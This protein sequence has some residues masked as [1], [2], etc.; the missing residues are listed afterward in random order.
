MPF[1]SASCR[2]ASRCATIESFG[3]LFPPDLAVSESELADD[4]VPRNSHSRLLGFDAFGPAFVVRFMSSGSAAE[5]QACI[6]IS[7]ESK[8]IRSLPFGEQ[9]I[10]DGVF[11][12]FI[13][14]IK[15]LDDIRNQ[16]I[17]EPVRK[18]HG[19]DDHLIAFEA[20]REQVEIRRFVQTAPRVFADRRRVG[21]P[22]PR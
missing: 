3:I 10:A 2:R 5:S 21:F 20:A 22:V 4:L 14:G 17:D 7:I 18:R 9:S 15:I 1:I 11:S 12:L 6:K 19:V 13:S 16:Q 8:L